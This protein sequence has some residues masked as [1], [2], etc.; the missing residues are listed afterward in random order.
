MG[1]SRGR[2]GIRGMAALMAVALLGLMWGCGSLDQSPLVSTDDGA[3][4]AVNNSPTAVTGSSPVL[5]GN[6]FAIAFGPKALA[7][8]TGGSDGST[9]VRWVQDLFEVDSDGSMGV[10]FPVYGDE[11]TVRIVT[12]TF[13]VDANTMR[14]LPPN[15]PDGT[16]DIT[17]EAYS[18]S[19]LGDVLVRFNPSGLE[20][21][22]HAS[23][24]VTV[25]GPVSIQQGTYTVYH[26][27]QDGT[28]KELRSKVTISDGV[29]TFD[30]QVPGFSEYDWDDV[31]EAGGP[32]GP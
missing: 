8:T 25:A 17:M 29:T 24:V 6:S 21:K 22:P 11:S 30:V 3:V 18:A 28:I 16:Y 26:I 27:Y 9:M 32:G 5:K 10:E 31:P 7:K 19:T 4:Q 23:L 2:F 12:A 20:F 14:S 13:A 1:K 15:G